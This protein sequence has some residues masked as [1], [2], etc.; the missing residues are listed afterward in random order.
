MPLYPRSRKRSPCGQNAIARL[1][2]VREGVLRK[3]LV[4]AL[5]NNYQRSTVMF[6]ITD[7]EW[8]AVKAGLEA[9]QQTYASA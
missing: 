5:K 7:D 4:M 3:H 8:P 9:K 6:S 2:A 1:G